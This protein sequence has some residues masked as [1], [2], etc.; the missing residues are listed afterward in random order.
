MAILIAGL[1]PGVTGQHADKQAEHESLTRTFEFLATVAGR[2]IFLLG[3]ITITWAMFADQWLAMLIGIGS[4]LSARFISLFFV[5]PVINCLP[6]VIP[7]RLTEQ[8]LLAW[9]GV[10]GTV[11]LALALSL[12]LLLDYWYTIQSIAYGVVLF[13][14]FV[15]T[16]TMPPVIRVLKLDTA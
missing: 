15:Q 11:T 1:V 13:T 10:R 12:P 14:L 2:L 5:F 8:C 6:G 9:D 16:T 7:V 4:V 3:G